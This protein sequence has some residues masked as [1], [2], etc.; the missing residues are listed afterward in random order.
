[1][2]E[3]NSIEKISNRFD[4]IL[5]AAKIARKIQTSEKEM[6]FNTHYKHKCTVTALQEIEKQFNL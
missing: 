1:M 4:L 6:I 3:P 2:I 5:A